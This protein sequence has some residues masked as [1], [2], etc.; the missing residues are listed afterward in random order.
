MYVHV[1]ITPQKQ[2]RIGIYEGDDLKQLALNFCKTF[3]LNKTMQQTLEENLRQS[4]HQ[5]LQDQGLED[6]LPSDLGYSCDLA[7]VSLDQGLMTQ[8]VMNEVQKYYNQIS[9]GM[10]QE[11]DIT[12]GLKQ[13]QEIDLADYEF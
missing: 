11:F 9:T 1:N 2:G 7:E 8:E 3:N 4:Y 5:Y 10:T 13:L 12:V 6:R